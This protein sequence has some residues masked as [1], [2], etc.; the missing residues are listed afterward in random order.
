VANSYTVHEVPSSI[1]DLLREYGY[2][3]SAENMG[4]ACEHGRAEFPQSGERD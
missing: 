1:S 2:P 3:Q 4:R